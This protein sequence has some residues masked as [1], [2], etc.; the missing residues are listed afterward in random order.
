MDNRFQKLI[1]YQNS[2]SSVS[3]GGLKDLILCYPV[4]QDNR[5]IVSQSKQSIILEWGVGYER[6]PPPQHAHI[7][8]R[9][10][11]PNK[12]SCTHTHSYLL[13]NFWDHLTKKGERER[14]RDKK[15]DNQVLVN[16]KGE[17]VL[18]SY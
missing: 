17:K 9:A 4:K 8:A 14:E 12:L 7:H 6:L 1:Q 15:K 11:I 13:P 18:K 3:W 10:R 16:R 5:I 2:N